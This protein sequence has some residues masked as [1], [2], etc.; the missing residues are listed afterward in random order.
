MGVSSAPSTRS[1]GDKSS[2]LN[3]TLFKA[4]MR[5][6]GSQFPPVNADVLSEERRLDGALEDC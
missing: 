6:D 3:S 1:S 5:I 2:E 4:S